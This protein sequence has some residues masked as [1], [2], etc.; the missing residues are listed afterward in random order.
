VSHNYREGTQ[1]SGVSV[2]EIVDGDIQYCGW[3][4]DIAERPLYY[5]KGT[6]IGW[7]SD[8]EP[9]VTVSSIKKAPRRR[10]ATTV[11]KN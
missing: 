4:F 10:V 7:G 9:L 8:G 2:Y 1:E 5:G 11:E 3:Y 6:I